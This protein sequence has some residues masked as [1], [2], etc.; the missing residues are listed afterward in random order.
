MVEIMPHASCH[1]LMVKSFSDE[2]NHS[3][4]NYMFSINISCKSDYE[5]SLTHHVTS[6][7]LFKDS[8][9]AYV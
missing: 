9:I 1:M 7:L 5:N 6:V 8:S 2:E 3:R 4:F